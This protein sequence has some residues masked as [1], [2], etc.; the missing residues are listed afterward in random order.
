MALK[1][2]NSNKLSFIYYQHILEKIKRNLN[3]R[4]FELKASFEKEKQKCIP[5][6][7][8]EHACFR[9]QHL[10]IFKSAIISFLTFRSILHF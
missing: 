9:L 5:S 8:E 4:K 3:E 6:D 7:V 1:R 10:V 2:E